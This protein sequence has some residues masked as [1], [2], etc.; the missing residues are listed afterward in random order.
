MFYT[1][2][3]SISILLN[4][5]TPRKQKKVDSDDTLSKIRTTTLLSGDAEDISGIYYHPKTRETKHTY[6]V[7]LSFIQAAIGDQVV[8]FF[9]FH[10]TLTWVA[11]I[12]SF[13]S[14]YDLFKVMKCVCF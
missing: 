2:D 12:E 14:M 13:L 6:E 5:F 8:Y 3:Y 10:L 1:Q 4:Y 11:T 7:L 9:Q